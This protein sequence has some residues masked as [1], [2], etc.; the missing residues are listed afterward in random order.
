MKDYNE[1][2]WNDFV[3]YDETSPTFL[4][5]KVDRKSGKNGNRLSAKVGDIAGGLDRN[6]G[7]YRTT[8]LNS[9][10]Y[11]HRIIWALLNG[12]IDIDKQVDH[13]D[14]NRRNNNIRNLRLVTATGNSRNQAVPH[15]NKTGVIGVCLDTYQNRYKAQWYDLNGKLKVKYFYIS[16]LGK[17]SAFLLACKYRKEMIEELNA[18]GAGYTERHWT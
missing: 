8:I 11:N 5:W 3:Y 1:I 12:S 17:D 10:Y 15:N 14:G 7:Y 13:L 2:K 18:Q 9:A 16:K 6:G 4:R